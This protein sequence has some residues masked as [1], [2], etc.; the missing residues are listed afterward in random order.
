MTRIGVLALQGNFADHIAGLN[1]FDVET[2]EVRQSTD[3][4]NLDAL[5]IPGGE[6]TSIGIVARRTGFLD[7]LSR[8]VRSGIPVWGTCAGLLMLADR[9]DGQ[10]EDADKK[11]Y[12]P[13]FGGMNIHAERNIFG[14]QSSSTVRLLHLT[15]VGEQ[16][17]L[18][19]S[20]FFIRAPGIKNVGAGVEILAQL[21]APGTPVHL[22]PVAVRQAQL[23]ATTFHS[24]VS[25][26]L[27]WT[28]YFLSMV[29]N[30]PTLPVCTYTR[31]RLAAPAR[32][33]PAS[34]GCQAVKRAFPRFLNGGVIMDVVNAEQ[35]R[36]AE[37]AGACAVMAL[38]RIPADII[39]SGGVARMSDPLLIKEVMDAVTIPVMAKA[40]IGHVGEARILQAL[41]VD[42]IDESEVLTIS[43]EKHHIR[44]SQ[45]SIPFVCGAED[46]G[47][48]LRRIAEGASMIRLKGNAGTGDVRNAVTHA[49]R[50]FG[51]IRLL[52]SMDDDEV[53]HYAKNIA[54]P[55]ELVQYVK[56]H[57]RLPVVTFAAGGIST[58]ADVM[59]LM[60]MGCDGVFVGSGIFKS[61]H[62]AERAAAMVDAC[63]NWSDPLH[64]ARCSEGLGNAMVGL[65]MPGESYALTGNDQYAPRNDQPN[66]YRGHQSKL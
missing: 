18:S 53:A 44:K 3:L 47:S 55:I 24:E 16:A 43:D 14:K 2:V 63:A 58:P 65:L 11:Q 48:A 52:Q 21:D 45:F 6:S 5:I 12:Q 59:L 31:Y 28:K 46:L 34:Q 35:A 40:R 39:V 54:A 23:L 60:E 37:Q 22:T 19:K 25:N 7:A 56:E 51:A 61:S 29:P 15:P 57:G 1:C 8:F 4:N 10:A 38:E 27:T 33:G 62:P 41:D 36:L 42:C 30:A 9:V 66:P 17:Q 32:L 64:V 50:T 20:A 13:L 49:R 26:D